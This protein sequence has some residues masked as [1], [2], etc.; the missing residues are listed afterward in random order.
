MQFIAEHKFML[1]RT[2]GKHGPGAY[3]KTYLLTE[4]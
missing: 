3:S 1:R 2:R 4:I